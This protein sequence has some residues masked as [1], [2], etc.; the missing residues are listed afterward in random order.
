[1]SKNVPVI[2]AEPRDRVGTR[3]SK[4]LRQAG[5]LP[6]VIYGHGTQPTSV[7]VDAKSIISAVKHGTHVIELR[8]GSLS[9]TCLVKELQYG[10]M[11]DDVIH[12]DLT[13]VNL[14][15][16]VRVSIAMTFVGQPEAAKR[17]GAVLTHD[18]QQLEVECKVRDIPEGIRIDMTQMEGDIMTVAQVKLPEGVIAVTDPHYAVARV[19]TVLEEAEGEAA[20]TTAGAEPEVLTAKKEAGAE[21]GAAEK[22]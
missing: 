8:V 5:R 13:R 19:V 17:P 14:E 16:T 7:S 15:E 21:G 2:E 1:M 12:V 22:K 18:V 10:W 4:R 20:A 3:Y 6:A 11:G 9:E